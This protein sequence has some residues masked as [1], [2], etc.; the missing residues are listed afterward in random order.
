MRIDIQTTRRRTCP[1]P[2]PLQRPPPAVQLPQLA[3]IISHPAN[4]TIPD[5]TGLNNSASFFHARDLCKQQNSARKFMTSS[6]F[7]CVHSP[8]SVDMAKYIKVKVKEI[9]RK[10]RSK[11]HNDHFLRFS[12]ASRASPRYG[13]ECIPEKMERGYKNRDSTFP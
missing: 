10:R 8:V 2:S 4:S 12:C 6:Q 5:A 1:L 9:E 11:W 3:R 13:F 7:S